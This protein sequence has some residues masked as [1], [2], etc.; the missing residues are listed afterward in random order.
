[1]NRSSICIL[2]LFMGLFV[3]ILPVK[4]ISVNEV[5]NLI[6][7]PMVRQATD[8]TC[9]V[10]AFQSILAFY[11]IEVREDV[12]AKAL[13]ADD[14]ARNG[15]I[16]KYAESRGFIVERQNNMTI[17]NLKKQI[18]ISMPVMVCLQAWP[19]KPLTMEQYKDTWDEGHWVIV[20]GYDANNIYVM[21]PST[22]G[23]YAFVP[24][25][26][27]IARWHDYEDDIT[28]PFI[29][30]G[31]TFKSAQPSKYNSLEILYME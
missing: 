12:L 3:G 21:D 29:H 23:N 14:Y 16:K 10:A 9:G 25:D 18:D 17:D 6:K 27:F 13:K 7:V 24:V 19:K 20:I 22:L 11:G 2:I 8:H 26:E 4:A 5:P 28:K 1:M 30:F 15:E 31:L